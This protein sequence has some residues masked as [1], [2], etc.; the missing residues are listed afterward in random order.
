MKKIILFVSLVIVIS[1]VFHNNVYANKTLS[2]FVNEERVNYD[3]KPRIINGRTMVPLRFTAE[4][5]G[6]IVDWSPWSNKVTIKQG[7]NEIYFFIGEKKY[8]KNGV[9]FEIDASLDVYEGRTL[10]PIRFMGEGLGYRVEWDQKDFNVLITDKTFIPILMYHHFKKGVNN[11][12]IIDPD[13]FKEHMIALK[14][15]GYE[16]IFEH[17]LLNYYQGIATLPKKP[18]L[19][20]FDDGYESNYTKAY[21]ILKELNMRATIYVVTNTIKEHPEDNEPYALSHLS[22]SQLREMYES[23][24][25]EVQS[26]THNMHKKGFDSQNNLTAYISSPINL[27]GT[28]EST[29]QYQNRVREDLLT[30]ISMIENN[31]GNDVISLAYPYG[32]SSKSSEKIAK[33]LGFSMTITTDVGV[34]YLENGN[35]LLKRINIHGQKSG[36]DIINDIIQAY[37]TSTKTTK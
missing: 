18:I 13:T 10:V 36:E 32:D 7:E 24:L 37:K 14:N 31:I 25:I 9:E 20:T 29:Q 8:Y 26:H 3:V 27:D 16:T 34:N 15:S 2:I 21:P 30:S 33:E 5:F 4:S 17:D 12:L 35:Y 11:S 6:G 1:F 28:L 23:G 19:I 22:W